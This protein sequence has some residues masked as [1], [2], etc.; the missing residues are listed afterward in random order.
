MKSSV[1]CNIKLLKGCVWNVFFALCWKQRETPLQKVSLSHPW[2]N[3]DEVCV[4][5][6]GELGARRMEREEWAWVNIYS[7]LFYEFPSSARVSNVKGRSS[8]SKRA[9]AENGNFLNV[10]DLFERIHLLVRLQGSLCTSPLFHSLPFWTLPSS[11]FPFL[12][13]L[14]APS[15]VCP[16]LALLL[17]DLHLSLCTYLNSLSPLGRPSILITRP[18]I[19]IY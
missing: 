1:S 6:C 12:S 19:T 11:L 7:M 14:S 18:L 3:L 4:Y 2:V 9:K 17:L 16:S 13:S 5:M 10:I 8:L 15:L